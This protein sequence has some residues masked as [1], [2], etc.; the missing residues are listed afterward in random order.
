MLR[1]MQCG[2]MSWLILTQTMSL[3]VTE[4]SASEVDAKEGTQ[5]NHQ[6]PF[7]PLREFDG[8]RQSRV[9][10]RVK[11]AL[12]DPVPARP[13]GTDS[14]LVESYLLEGKLAEGNA[15]LTARLQ[16]KPN[17][18]Q[19]R[20]GL[21]MV[22]FFQGFEHLTAG[23]YRHGLR[24]ERLARNSLP[25]LSATIPQNPNPQ[26]ISYAE[27]RVMLQKFVDDLNAAEA[28]LAAIQAPDVKLPLHVGLI[29]LDATGQGKLVSGKMIL[30]QNRFPFTPADI[31]SFVVG[32]DRG[33]VCW[34]RG[35]LHLLA[36]WGEVL[37]AVDGQQMF[38]TAGHLF[39][40]N[41]V[42]PHAYLLEEPRDLE[43]IMRFDTRMIFD[44][45]AYLHVM[46]FP[47]KEPERMK[48]SLQ[49]LESAVAMSREMWTFY[50][51]ETDDDHEWIPNP[52]QTGVLQRQVTESMIATWKEVLDEGDLVLK[53]ERLL[54]FWR[55]TP[56]KTRGINLR[57]VFTEPKPLDPF[58]WLQGTAATPYLENGVISRFADP[59]FGA[60]LE[61]IFGPQQFWGFALW[62]N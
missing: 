9:V 38:E 2:L 53:G 30:V 50:L 18:D 36:A 21:G 57:R 39:F 4:L 45:I 54:P 16:A 19:A 17:D 60:N 51:Q 35:Y 32:F 10:D 29:Q 61:K 52:K 12:A 1:L 37:L 44:L 49:H 23:L 48:S 47:L 58:L 14:P 43:A 34:L 33:D 5:T 59:Q 24:T 13:Q 46:R 8:F 26:P 22:Q 20:F 40:E 41:P 42:T 31:D 7:P 11:L 27:L 3:G 56:A 62:F 28:T 25:Q 15:A 6:A 55:G